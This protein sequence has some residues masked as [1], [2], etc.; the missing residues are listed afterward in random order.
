M[1]ERDGVLDFLQNGSRIGSDPQE[2]GAVRVRI[3]IFAQ[4]DVVAGAGVRD[5]VDQG[6]A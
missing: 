3:T 2:A 5:D 1:T 6:R 4:E